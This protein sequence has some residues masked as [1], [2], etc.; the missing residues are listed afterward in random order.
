MGG[1]EIRRVPDDFINNSEYLDYI[2]NGGLFAVT[3]VYLDEDLGERFR[4]LIKGFDAN[5][6]YQIDY[7]GDGNVIM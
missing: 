1:V 2:F 4:S 6:Y 7:A 3:N 5:K